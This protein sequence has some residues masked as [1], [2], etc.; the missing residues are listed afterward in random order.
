MIVQLIIPDLLAVALL[1]HQR[2]AAGSPRPESFVRR[3]RSVSTAS[4]V[5]AARR[6]FYRGGGF[7]PIGAVSAHRAAVVVV[8][9]VDRHDKFRLSTQELFSVMKTTGTAD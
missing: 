8:D 3:M 1:G 4:Y 9:P 2:L 7:V 5:T 6:M